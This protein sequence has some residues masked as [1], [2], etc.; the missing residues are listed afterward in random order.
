MLKTIPQPAREGGVFVHS[1]GGKAKL[2]AKLVGQ[3]SP[4]SLSRTVHTHVAMNFGEPP[5][6][7]LVDI[8]PHQ[9]DVHERAGQVKFMPM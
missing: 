4:N 7:W 5:E 8:N 6:K 9:N 1:C 3:H 2:E